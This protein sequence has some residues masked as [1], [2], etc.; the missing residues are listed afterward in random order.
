MLVSLLAD[1]AESINMIQLG[2]C[3]V[4][5]IA[6]GIM[7]A[8]VCMHRNSYRKNFIVSLLVLPSL[9][10]FIMMLIQEDLV[11][12]IVLLGVF[13]LMRTSVEPGESRE[14][15]SL[16]WAIGIGIA[17][18]LGY[19]I[20][21]ISFSLVL[22]VLLLMMQSISFG[23]AGRTSKRVIKIMIPENLDYP[24]LFD[25]LFKKYLHEFSMESVK[26]TNMGSL[27]EIAYAVKFKDIANE[28]ALIDE[29]RIRNGNLTVISAKV[30]SH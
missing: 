24:N 2:L 30:E 26:T 3:T 7:I 8:L 25:D 4:T 15:M 6:L 20:Y 21:V 29:I 14:T 9:I 22:S 23:G 17:T 13:G 12:G 27:Y 10:Q 1:K 16:L 5:S 19:I 28:K 11:R 18:G